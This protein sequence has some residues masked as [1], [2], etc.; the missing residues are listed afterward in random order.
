MKIYQIRNKVNNKKYIGRAN[1]VLI[2]FESHKNDL[3]I[4]KHDNKHLQS[5]WNK[6][7][8]E[9]F[10]FEIIQECT[11]IEE[12]KCMEQ[13]WLDYYI[14]SNQWDN[15]YNISTKSTGGNLGKEVNEKLRVLSIGKN[16]PMYGK[17]GKIIR[18]QDVNIQYNLV[19]R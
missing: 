1:D 4:N 11:S 5:A 19:I 14:L 16:N 3:L 8:S 13:W 6:Y 12:M 10:I 17:K 9:K 2:R 7:K 15:L 18:I